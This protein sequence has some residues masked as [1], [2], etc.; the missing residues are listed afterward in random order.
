[1]E[2]LAG[3]GPPPGMGAAAPAQPG[4]VE[5]CNEEVRRTAEPRS[6]ATAGPAMRDYS[7]QPVKAANY[8]LT[9]GPSPKERGEMPALIGAPVAS[10]A[11]QRNHWVD[12]TSVGNRA[13]G[14]NEKCRMKNVE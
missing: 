13:A 2:L 12:L 10:S 3:R 7:G 11:V 5:A 14:G 1:M 9:P 8:G 6:A 4:L